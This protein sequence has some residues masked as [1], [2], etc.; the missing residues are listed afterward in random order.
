MRPSGIVD[1]FEVRELGNGVRV[2]DN[3]SE[4][5]YFRR[6]EDG[7]WTFVS[8]AA[9]DEERRQ[10]EAAAF[11][12]ALAGIE[13]RLEHFDDPIPPSQS[14]PNTAELERTRTSLLNER[15]ATQARIA[16]LENT[17]V[18]GGPDPAA[19]RRLRRSPL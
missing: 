19:K 12:R 4:D 9:T 1:A 14:I 3:G 2:F 5:G 8:I 17:Q 15:E 11:R 16:A 10:A 7:E 13:F 18:S 6:G